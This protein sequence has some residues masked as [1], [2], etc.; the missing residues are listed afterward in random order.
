MVLSVMAGQIDRWQPTELVSMLLSPGARQV[1]NSWLKTDVFLDEQHHPRMLLSMPHDPQSF[2]DLV[3]AA[4]PNLVPAVV[5]N[6]LLRKGIVESLESRHVLLK[7]STYAPLVEKGTD[8]VGDYDTDSDF[9]NRRRRH[10][11]S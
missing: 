2:A 5:L 1:V 9:D 11:D 4:N 10:S 7:R 3:Q 6:E 8:H